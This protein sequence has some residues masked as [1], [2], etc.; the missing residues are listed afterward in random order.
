MKTDLP[1]IGWDSVDCF[2]LPQD[3]DHW[4]ALVNT[5]MNILFQK[6]NCE[7]LICNDYCKQ[8]VSRLVNNV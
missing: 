4:R 5:V 1:E 3:R 6:K 7:F 8:L 2:G